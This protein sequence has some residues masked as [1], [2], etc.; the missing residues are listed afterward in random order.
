MIEKDSS[1]HTRFRRNQIYTKSARTGFLHLLEWLG[2][3]RPEVI[4]LPSYIGISVREGSGV[5]DP[6]CESGIDYDFYRVNEDLS[7]EIGD[8][9]LKIQSKNVKAIFVIHYFGIVQSDMKYIR[10]LC[11]DNSIILIEDCAHC[12]PC[13][14]ERNDIG[15]TGN[16]SLFSIHKVLPV[17]DGGILRINSSAI[18]PPICGKNKITNESLELYSTACFEDI[19]AIRIRNYQKLSKYL[20]SIKGIARLCPEIDRETVPFNFPILIKEKARFDIYNLLRERGVEAIALYY[21]LVPEIG[22]EDYP[23][24]HEIST[25]ILNLPIHQ[26]IGDP[27][28][29]TIAETLEDVVSL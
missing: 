25:R 22:I 14:Y 10:N 26:E 15:L 2:I 27:E 18:L 4:L 6:V 17:K 13:S 23:V 11:N 24:S 28:L 3:E 29:I 7:A 8:L 19:C 12:M 16:F 21:K 9:E 1:D 20:S 5:L